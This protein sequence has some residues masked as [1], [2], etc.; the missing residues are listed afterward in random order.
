MV[1]KSLWKRILKGGED[2][3]LCLKCAEVRLGR[4]I[5]IDDLMVCLGNVHWIIQWSNDPQRGVNRDVA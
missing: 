4:L 1:K 5:N 2:C 3:V